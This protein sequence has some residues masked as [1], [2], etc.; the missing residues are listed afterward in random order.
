[1]AIIPQKEPT[2]EA[3]IMHDWL[4]FLVLKG[5]VAR[6]KHGVY[7]WTVEGADYMAERHAAHGSYNPIH[8][9]SSTTPIMY[10]REIS[11]FIDLE[12]AKVFGGWKNESAV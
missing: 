9:P 5:F 12:T 10:V 1:M 6:S 2:G 11:K 4:E 8:D 3:K 7:V